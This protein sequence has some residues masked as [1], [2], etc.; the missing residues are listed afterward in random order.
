[1]TNQEIIEVS[2]LSL[3]ARELARED[4]SASRYLAILQDNSLFPDAVSFRAH[5]LP[6]NRAI[7]WG[8]ACIRELRAPDK[9]QEGQ[10][11]LD[12][13]ERWLKVPNDA[14]R[15]AA[16]ES[17]DKAGM[18]SPADL[19]A[20]AVFFSGGSMTPPGSPE[21]PPPPYAARKMAAGSIVAAVLSQTPEKAAERYKRALALSKDDATAQ[22]Q[23]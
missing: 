18:S 20:L 8:A 21:T 15:W 23:I 17:A 5:E 16:K 3:N 4:L 14:T 12:C 19:L 22:P 6:T 1:M 7:E 11:S 9:K 10:G 13:V 2:N